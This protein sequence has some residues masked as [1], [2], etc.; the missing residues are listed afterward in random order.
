MFER[1]ISHFMH[2]GHKYR[3]ERTHL[4]FPSLSEVYLSLYRLKKRP[5]TEWHYLDMLGTD[6]H[7]NRLINTKISGRNLSSYVNY[8]CHCGDLDEN[9]A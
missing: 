2:I 6:F 5:V 8:N 9:H 7:Q 4:P 1:I 3:K